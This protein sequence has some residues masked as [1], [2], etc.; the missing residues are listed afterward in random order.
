MKLVTEQLLVPIQIEP[1]K[2]SDERCNWIPGE[3][4][5][6]CCDRNHKTAEVFNAKTAE[7]PS[8]T[9]IKV[10][11]SKYWSKPPDHTDISIWNS[12]NKRFIHNYT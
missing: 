2:G 8:S 12:W 4:R 1:C 9:S 6:T 11:R 7:P 10:L 3:E 5:P